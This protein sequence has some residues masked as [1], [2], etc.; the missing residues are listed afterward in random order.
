MQIPAYLMS[1]NDIIGVG[2]GGDCCKTL[3]NAKVSSPALLPV[4]V[5]RQL[6][7]SEQRWFSSQI[8]WQPV[9]KTQQK[10]K[11]EMGFV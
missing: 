4:S 10:G 1:F 7:K 2:G 11:F 5:S 6:A 3:F 9:S 8:A